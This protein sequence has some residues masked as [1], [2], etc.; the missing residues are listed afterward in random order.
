MKRNFERRKLGRG[1]FRVDISFRH[2]RL[3][4]GVISIIIFPLYTFRKAETLVSVVSPF[5]FYFF[6]L[7][8]RRDKKNTTASNFIRKITISLEEKEME[9]AR[10]FVN[11]GMFDA[12][13]IFFSRSTSKS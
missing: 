13:N 7:K 10:C 1:S 11:I 8:F 6:F 3:N 9:T 5:F 12:A 4:A 2:E